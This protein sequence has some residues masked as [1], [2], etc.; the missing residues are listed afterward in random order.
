[1]VAFSGGVDSTLLARAAEAPSARSAA[2]DRGFGDLSGPRAR[3]GPA[4]RR[5]PRHA[6]RGRPDRRAREPRLR[7]QRRQP[8]LLLQGRAL[9]AARARSPRAR[10]PARSSTAPTWTTAAITGPGM[11]AAKER[12]VRAPLIEAELW[13]AEIRALS[14]ELGLPTW[15]KPSFACLSSR[16]QY[17]DRITPE[18]LRQVDAAEAFSAAR[19]SPV[20]RAASRSPGPARDDAR[21]NAAPLGGRPAHAIVARSP[22]AG[23]SLRHARPRRLSVRQRQFLLNAIESERLMDRE[24]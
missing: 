6:P 5:A 19:L 14:R 16:F 10:A 20:P 18:K 4:P 13:K 3:R 11:K 23:L 22:R 17:G 12:G 1:M 9:R 2:R 15:D 21:R 8:L 7:A 24:E